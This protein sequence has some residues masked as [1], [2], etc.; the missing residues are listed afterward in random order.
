MGRAVVIKEKKKGKQ[1][2]SWDRSSN[3]TR[4]WHIVE[5]CYMQL[6]YKMW[7]RTTE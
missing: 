6:R 2:V 1:L 5:N 7:L 4:E 3:V